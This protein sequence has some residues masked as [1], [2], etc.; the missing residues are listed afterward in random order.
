MVDSSIEYEND[1]IEDDNVLEDIIQ[2]SLID[3]EIA[4]GTAF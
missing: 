4:A 2:D 1:F 3:E